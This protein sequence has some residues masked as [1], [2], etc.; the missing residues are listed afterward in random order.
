MQPYL[1]LDEKSVTESHGVTFHLNPATKHPDNPVLLPGEPHEWDSLQVSWPATVLYSAR[2]RKFR[3]WY[4]GFDVIQTPARHWFPG[5]AESSDGI[6]WTKP[7]LDQVTFLDRPTNK[8]QPNWI[9]WPA[10]FPEPPWGT[11]I[12]SF[13]FENPSPSAPVEQRFGSYWWHPTQPDDTGEAI[14]RYPRKALAFSPDGIR[15]TY[16]CTPY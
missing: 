13:V 8:L 1:I 15:W 10:N 14:R 16:D 4:S 6:H 9:D 11:Y 7:K 2:E 3:C 5:Y 12:L